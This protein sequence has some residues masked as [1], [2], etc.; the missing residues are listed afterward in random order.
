MSSEEETRSDGQEPR[1]S[2]TLGEK[3]AEPV[4]HLAPVGSEVPNGGFKAW[5]QVAGAFCLF[6]NTW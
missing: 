2:I 1:N 5:L 3:Q 6:F 4:S